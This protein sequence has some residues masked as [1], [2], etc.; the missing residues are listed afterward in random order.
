MARIIRGPGVNSMSCD[1]ADTWLDV[2][3]TIKTANISFFIGALLDGCRILCL[4]GKL[5]RGPARPSES[6]S[7]GA[8]HRMRDSVKPDAAVAQGGIAQLAHLSSLRV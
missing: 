8:Q 1:W 5:T 2:K 6:S 7:G 4:F 3:P